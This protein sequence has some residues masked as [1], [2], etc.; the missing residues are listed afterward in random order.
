MPKAPIKLEGYIGTMRVCNDSIVGYD[1][2][3]VVF[4]DNFAKMT[5][6]TIDGIRDPAADAAKAD[7][8]NFDELLCPV[9]DL[10]LEQQVIEKR[11]SSA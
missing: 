3:N 11:F 5:Y 7:E 6:V 2:K 10:N 9:S 4:T 8:D 1:S